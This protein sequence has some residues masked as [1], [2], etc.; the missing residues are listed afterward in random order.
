MLTI[1]TN[2]HSLFG[3]RMLSAGRMNLDRSME[4]L[5]SGL[6]INSAQDDASGLAIS[7]RMTAQIRGLNQASRNINDGISLLQTAEGAMQE[8]TNLLQR[9]RELA[10][11]AGSDALS[12]SDRKSLQAE[13]NQIKQEIDRIGRDTTFNG[14]FILR[15]KN[16][17]SVTN[18]DAVDVQDGLRSGWLRNAEQMIIDRFGLTGVGSQLDIGYVEDSGNGFV[19]WVENTYSGS[20]REASSQKLY[21][22]LS[23]FTPVT[24]QDG[25][26]GPVYN[27][28]I[29]AHEMVH[30]VM[31]VTMNGLDINTWYHEGSAELIHGGDERIFGAM[32]NRLNGNGNNVNQ[33]ADDIVNAIASGHT[34]NDGSDPTLLNEQYSASYVALRFLHDEIKAAGGTGIDELM[35]LLNANKDNT[36]NPNYALNEALADLQAAHSTFAYNSENTFLTA[37]AAPGGAGSLYLREMYN[38][39]DLA[40]SDTGAVGGLDADGG[41]ILTASGVVPN[42]AGYQEDPLLG[43]DPNWQELELSNLSGEDLLLQ[44]GANAR[45]TLNVTMYGVNASSLNVGDVDITRNHS[46]AIIKFDRALAQIDENRGELGAQMNRLETAH[47]VALN[48]AENLSSARSRILDADIA[49]E[50]TTLTRENILQQ[51]AVSVLSQAN[52]VPQLALRLLT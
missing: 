39:G 10:V 37:F 45:E 41:A 46:L 27:D 47:A 19:A 51:A 17:G 29:I 33:A 21:I 32:I 38:S 22:D 40:N 28:R 9:G 4:R 34:W 43:F 49:Q 42:G 15:P 11:Q 7:D 16:N 44:I 36:L 6:R 23:D 50:T 52:S 26:S 2:V 31:A 1:N 48:V 35:G 12:D 3:N 18:Q 5:S 30:A 14:Q 13:V 8:V 25:G 24:D 20:T